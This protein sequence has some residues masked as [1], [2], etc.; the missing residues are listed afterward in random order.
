MECRESFSDIVAVYPFATG[1]IK[2]TIPFNVKKRYY[3][4]TDLGVDELSDLLDNRI[5]YSI[6]ESYSNQ[7]TIEIEERQISLKS[8]SKKNINGRLYDVTLTLIIKDKKDISANFMDEID[9]E[10]H[11]FICLLADGSY[12]LVRTSELCYDCKTEEEFSAEYELKQ[13]I[14]METY[15]G[16]IRI[17][18]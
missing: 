4:L 11:D 9:G 17:V 6:G 14:S 3:T 1:E 5:Y 7:N 15:N 13:T 10:R 18:V 16:I 2:Y 12:L 8:V